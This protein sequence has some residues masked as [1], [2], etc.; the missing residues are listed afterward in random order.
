[1]VEI[2][3]RSI[4]PTSSALG[5]I[6]WIAIDILHVIEEQH[7]IHSV[8]QSPTSSYPSMRPLVSATT[9]KMQPIRG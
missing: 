9:V 7:R 8:R 2:A 5:D 6:H 3:S 1:M 4:W